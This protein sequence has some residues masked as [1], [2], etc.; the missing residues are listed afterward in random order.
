MLLCGDLD[1]LGVAALIGRLQA[2]RGELVDD[3]R[4][5]G[6]GL[7][8]LVDRDDDGHVGGA[9]V[10]D[11]FQRLGHDSVVGCYDDDDDVGDFGSAG[12]HA[13]EGLVAWGVEEDDLAAEGGGVGLG[14]FDLVGADVLGDAS[15]FAAGYVGGADGVEER[16]FAVVDVAHDRD[17]WRT[18]DLDHAGGVFEE[19]FDGLVFELLFDGDDGRVGAELAGDVFDELGVEGL[20]DGDEDALHQEGGDQ[21]FAADVE[22]FG[23]VLDG[24]AFGDRDGLGDRKGLAGEGCAAK[25]WWRLEALHRAFFGL[26]VT[27]SSAA[28]A[29]TCGGAH[30]GRR[31]FAGAGKG[32]GGS[33]GTGAEAGACAKGRAWAA[34]GEAGASGCSA[35]A[36]WAAGEGAGGV[37]GAACAGGGLLRRTRAGAAG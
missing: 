17:H 25:A 4:G 16:G 37:H 27:L 24:D 26:L 1:E 36:G 6:F 21:V 20:V 8:D 7:V 14:D 33:A 11:G 9:G 22:F 5:V 13:G 18:D 34:G 28:L 10:V 12:A 29:G 2:A 30:A 32:S 23:E 19:A 15:G 3:A 31:G 35:G